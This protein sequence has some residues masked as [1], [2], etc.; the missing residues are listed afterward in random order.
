MR[1]LHEVATVEVPEQIALRLPLAGVGSRACAYLIDLLIQ[2]VVVIAASVPLLATWLDSAD[3]RPDPDGHVDL[4]RILLPLMLFHA[5]LFVVNFGYFAFFEAFTGGR[6]PGKRAMG[7]RVIS[8]GGHP[9]RGGAALVRNLLRAVDSLPAGYLVGIVTMFISREAKRLGDY[10]AGTLVVRE[11]RERDPMP[12][13]AT[14]TGPLPPPE[15]AIVERF[16]ERRADLERWPRK[17]LARELADRVAARLGH[18]PP[19]DAERY[20]EE[21]LRDG[22]G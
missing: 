7:L 2:S 17:T 18:A 20:L 10:A 5:I 11:R 1:S 22:H 21:V 13:R 12:V 8:D 4:G 19:A 14:G 9:I 3:L 16:L 6:S 15:R